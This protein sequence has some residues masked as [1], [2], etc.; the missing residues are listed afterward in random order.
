M[1]DYENKNS[2]SQILGVTNP[3]FLKVSKIINIDFKR[4]S[5][6]P[7]YGERLLSTPF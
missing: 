2:K 6:Y 3:L 4:V 1:S 7:S 5:K